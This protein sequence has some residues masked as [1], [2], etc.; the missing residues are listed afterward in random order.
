MSTKGRH[1]VTCA[2]ALLTLMQLSGTSVMNI[3]FQ[4]WVDVRPHTVTQVAVL[5]IT[6]VSLLV[7]ACVCVQGLL[8]CI[9]AQSTVVTQPTAVFVLGRLVMRGGVGA[10]TRSVD[11]RC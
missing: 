9:Y 6:A 3:C 4:I 2:P 8:G 11:S 1:H 5:G 10:G 7:C